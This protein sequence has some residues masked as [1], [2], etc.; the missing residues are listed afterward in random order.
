MSGKEERTLLIAHKEALQRELKYIAQEIVKYEVGIGNS[1]CD[2]SNTNSSQSHQ[3]ALKGQND[4]V[5]SAESVGSSDDAM[6]IDPA[7]LASGSLNSETN[8]G[9]ISSDYVT[10]GQLIGYSART[11]GK[12]EAANIFVVTND[13]L[14][15]DSVLAM[16][17]FPEF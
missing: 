9:S 6:M 13:I 14:A 8:D 17:N 16:E 5:E 12:E 11:D 10:N 1:L 7:L 3:A 4:A 15:I 2:S